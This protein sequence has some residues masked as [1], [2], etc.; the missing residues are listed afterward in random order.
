M[1]Q[2]TL[3]AHVPA[4]KGE[5]VAFPA[6]TMLVRDI[7]TEPVKWFTPF[8]TNNTDSKTYCEKHSTIILSNQGIPF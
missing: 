3:S 7:V 1:I 8:T 4:V 2:V 6:S 5:S